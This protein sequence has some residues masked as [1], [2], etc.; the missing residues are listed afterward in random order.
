M[1]VSRAVLITLFGCGTALLLVGSCD[2]KSE[3]KPVP[4]PAAAA[5]K[6]G[7]GATAGAPP[8]IDVSG[9]DPSQVKGFERLLD[10]KASACGKSHSLRTSLKSDPKCRRSIFAARYLVTLLKAGLL[11]SEAEEHYDKRFVSPDKG[12]CDVATAPMRGNANAPVAICEF[13]DFQCPHCRL[14]GPIL[15]KLMEEFHDQVKVYYKNYPISKLHPEAADAAAAAVAAGKQ[16]KFWPMHDKLFANQDKLA[17]T[18]LE[19]Y[20][21]EMKLDVKKWKADLVPARDDVEKDH[22]EGEKLDITGTPTIYIND[23]KY[24][25]PLRYEAMKDWVE[26]ELNR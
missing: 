10:E 18:D 6:P 5:P 21:G 26:E 4:A 19:R 9:L 25:G 24:A 7:S 17:P 11:P 16:G 8:G 20:A 15:A 12:R 1:R 23:R 3:A 13:S 22:A 14:A 2:S